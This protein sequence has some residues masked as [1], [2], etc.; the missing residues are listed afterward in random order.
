[1]AEERSY[2]L[3][4]MR[5][6]GLAGVIFQHTM[7]PKNALLADV[8]ALALTM[9]FVLSGFLITGLL[10]DARQRAEARS[11]SRAGVLKRFYI[12]R[13]LRIF[14][15]Y[16]GVLLV[17]VLMGEPETRGYINYLLTY[18][19]NFLL[20]KVG[21]NLPPI[22]PFWSLAVEEHFYFFWP[23]IALFGSRRVMWTSATLM[24]VL[25]VVTRG[26]ASFNGAG[27]NLA[28]MPTYASLDGIAIGCML[29]IAYRDMTA[30]AREPWIRRAVAFGGAVVF[31]RML[32]MIDGGYNDW[33]NTIHAFPFALVTV[34]L[35]DR[36]ARG[37]LPNWLNSRAL[38]TMG[39]TTY[40]GYVVHR[41]VMHFLGYD[42]ERG[43]HVFFPVLIVTYV[44]AGISWVLIESPINSLKRFWPYVP[45]PVGSTAPPVAIPEA[46]LANLPGSLGFAPNAATPST[47]G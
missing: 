22:T 37:V 7:N 8:P 26:V 47:S 33:V 40:A 17:A 27:Y 29:A 30:E 46:V 25:S 32:M 24:V 35:I 28:T 18:T 38:G 15:V 5:A 45:R 16:Y 44:I 23:V 21:H 31:I 4:S 34:W 1:M 20:A 13:F 36:G 11:I 41:Y 19:T 42:A 9:F 2:Q 14:P 39:M 3:D 43:F 6:L 10:L 12:R